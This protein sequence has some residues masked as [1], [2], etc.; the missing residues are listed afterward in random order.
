MKNWINYQDSNPIKGSVLNEVTEIMGGYFNVGEI[1]GQIGRL[2]AEFATKGSGIELIDLPGGKVFEPGIGTKEIKTRDLFFMEKQKAENEL[3]EIAQV[4]KKIEAGEIQT[5]EIQIKLNKGRQ[6][7]QTVKIEHGEILPL[8]IRQ[9][10]RLPTGQ[11]MP[12]TGKGTQEKKVYKQFMQ[13]AVKKCFDLIEPTAPEL[14][15]TDK[16]FFTGLVLTLAGV[17]PP[18]RAYNEGQEVEPHQIQ[19]YKDKLSDELR[20]YKPTGK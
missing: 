14:T 17:M 11:P 8:I 3:H 6:S 4:I 12:K 20:Y 15:E 7:A 5:M 16:L 1:W 2:M 13:D 10:K 19:D 9:L 18:P